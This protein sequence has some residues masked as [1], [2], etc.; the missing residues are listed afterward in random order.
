MRHS[1]PSMLSVGPLAAFLAVAL[2]ACG[3]DESPMDETPTGTG[4][5]DAGTDMNVEAAPLGPCSWSLTSASVMVSGDLGFVDIARPGTFPN[6][7]SRVI[8]LGSS[9][10]GGT[11]V[12]RVVDRQFQ[13]GSQSVTCAETYTLGFFL[14]DG[15]LAC[16]AGTTATL[17]LTEVSAGVWEGTIQGEFVYNPSLRDAITES[18]ELRFT[19][20][21]RPR[22]GPA[23][24]A[25]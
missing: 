13:P 8:N 24:C 16:E 7:E 6:E 25:T 5:P 10:A 19:V 4:N 9:M 14:T 18:A 11:G 22:G 12:V 23:V 21:L 15:G 20:R 3:G 17:S 2:F 1:F